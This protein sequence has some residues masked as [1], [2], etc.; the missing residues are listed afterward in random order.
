M[1]TFLQK[2]ALRIV[3]D[4]LLY[5]KRE[6]MT[7]LKSCNCKEFQNCCNPLVIFSPLVATLPGNDVFRFSRKLL[8]PSQVT[9]MVTNLLTGHKRHGFDP[10]VGESPQSRTWQPLQYSCLENPLD[11]RSLAGYGPQGCKESDITEHTNTHTL[12][13]ICCPIFLCNL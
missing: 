1:I 13:G 10:W 8:R 11:Y 3:R 2:H 7:C 6:F 4:N 12:R 9:L 5:E